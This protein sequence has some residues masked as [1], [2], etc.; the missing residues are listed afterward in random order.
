M[1]LHVDAYIAWLDGPDEA[2]KL[3]NFVRQQIKPKTRQ[4]ILCRDLHECRY[5]GARDEPLTIDHIWP[6][7]YGGSDDDDNLLTCCKTCN[8]SKGAKTLAGWKGTP[9]RQY[10]TDYAMKIRGYDA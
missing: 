1:R 9:G 6:A 3:P 5:C 7:A 10:D 8:S 2:D 4:R